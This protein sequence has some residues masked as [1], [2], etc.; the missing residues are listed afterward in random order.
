M[1]LYMPSVTAE[2]AS[3]EYQQHLVALGRSKET[4]R[5]RLHYTKMLFADLRKSPW[6]VTTSD[7]ERW[8]VA[9]P[10]WSQ[11]T[12]RIAL[13]SVRQF[14]SWA[15][16][17][18]RCD[19]SPAAILTPPK[20]PHYAAHPIP[21]HVLGDALAASEGD[22]WWSLR[23]LATTGLRRAECAGLTSDHVGGRWLSITGKGNRQ[24]RIPCPD[25]VA[26]HVASADGP[27]F[28][29]PRGGGLSP[30]TLATR[31]R[32]ATGGY[33]CHTL[34]HRYAS[35]IYAAT[36]DVLAVQQLLGHASLATTQ[37]YLGIGDDR[38]IAAAATAA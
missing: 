13:T 25:D 22:V 36:G 32:R 2:R 9:H 33:G 8:L 38:L 23:I 21:E 16:E 5:V 28:R 19:R 10:S 11:Q 26:E 24:R 7:I 17:S 37:V 30:I 27:V 3:G 29:G 6:D 15:V 4:V 12:R 20:Q 1:I 14:Y 31:V 18:G 35:R 34:R